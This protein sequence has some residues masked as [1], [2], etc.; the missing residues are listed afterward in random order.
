MQE[1]EN[2]ED[3]QEKLRRRKE[4]EENDEDMYGY[5]PFALYLIATSSLAH[6]RFKRISSVPRCVSAVHLL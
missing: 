5:P 4:F 1:L 2:D 6:L 3:L